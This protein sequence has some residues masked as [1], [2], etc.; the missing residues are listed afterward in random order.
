LSR[1]DHLYFSILSIET[2]TPQVSSPK[3][4]GFVVCSRHPGVLERMLL[5][6]KTGMHRDWRISSE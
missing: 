2:Q 1:P 4:A 5:L 6:I 3:L